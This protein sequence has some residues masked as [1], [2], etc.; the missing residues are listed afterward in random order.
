MKVIVMYDISDDRIRELLANRL[1]RLGLTRVQRSVFVGWGSSQKIKDIE[2]LASRLID[3]R[4]DV[5]HIVPID[6]SY[7]RRVKV[8]GTPYGSRRTLRVV[9]VV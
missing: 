6:E 9:T 3:P 5:V 8:I 4:T 7:W 2:R 1:Q